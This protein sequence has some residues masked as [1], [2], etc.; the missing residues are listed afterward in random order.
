MNAAYHYI[1]HS[2]PLQILAIVTVVAGL[3]LWWRS[4]G[5]RRKLLWLLVPAILLAACCTP[6]AAYLAL[7]SLEWH[8]PSD[9]RRLAS[10]PVIVVLGGGMWPADS[11]RHKAEL[12]PDTL[13]RC[14]H[15]AELYHQGPRCPVLVSGGKVRAKEPGPPVADVMRQL[16]SQL[17][18]PAADIWVE[19]TSRSTY[20][21]ATECRKQL[22]VRKID[23][24]TLVTSAVHMV[25]AARC[26]RRQGLT[27]VPAPCY[28]RATRLPS[29]IDP[30][31][32]SADAAR[33]VQDAYHEWIGLLWY[34]LS[35][36]I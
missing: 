4:A 2:S 30:L 8:Y 16:L 14:L 35:D 7:G 24:V 3:L 1:A 13:Y 9:D 27:V 22:A 34:W 26:F 33:G 11:L 5:S 23:H 32:P 18:V 21:N 31:L 20:E 17:G 12:S 25:R 29:G 6:L 28:H 19:E 10:S 15:A 36:R